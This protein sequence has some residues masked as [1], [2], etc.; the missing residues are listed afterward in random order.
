MHHAASWSDAVTR[1]A[2]FPSERLSED[3]RAR[4]SCSPNERRERRQPEKSTVRLE[5]S[6]QNDIL[7]I[8]KA[9]APASQR[10]SIDMTPAGGGFYAL[11]CPM[12]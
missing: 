12:Q 2:F 3:R 6:M 10:S 4:K 8:A 1:V 7:S 5:D 11:S 9:K